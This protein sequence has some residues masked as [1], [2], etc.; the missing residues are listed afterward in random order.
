MNDFCYSKMPL[1]YHY[2]TFNKMSD[3]STLAPNLFQ[4]QSTNKIIDNLKP[5]AYTGSIDSNV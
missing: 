4:I 3:L 2:V 1:N 5:F